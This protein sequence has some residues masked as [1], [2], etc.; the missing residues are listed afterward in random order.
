MMRYFTPELYL[1]FSSG[2]PAV[3][4][5]AEAEWEQANQD[6]H[7]YLESITPKMPTQA[8]DYAE[9]ICLQDTEL[10]DLRETRSERA[11]TIAM[12]VRNENKCHIYLTYFSPGTIRQITAISA[13]PTRPGLVH[14]LYDEFASDERQPGLFLHKIMLSDGR[15]VEIPFVDVS[16]RRQIVQ[17]LGRA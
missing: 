8:K 15:Q 6:Y 16:V 12:V 4:R 7:R 17:D 14:W 9:N 13:W 11:A 1:R 2:N 10:I 5:S 3:A